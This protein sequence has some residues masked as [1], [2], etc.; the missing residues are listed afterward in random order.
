M[1][2]LGDVNLKEEYTRIIGV[3]QSLGLSN[4]EARVYIA[5][6]AHGFGD[7]ETIASTARIPRTS[8]Y[9]ALQSLCSKEF[10]FST[11]GRPSIYKPEMPDRIKERILREVSN[12][13]DKLSSIHEIVRDKGEPQLVFTITGKVRVMTKIGELLDKSSEKFMISTPTFSEIRESHKKRL[14][15]AIRRGIRVT[16][17]TE[18]GQKVPE[19]ADVHWRRGLIATDVI[20]DGGEALIAS[21][22]LNA[23]GFTDNP[24]LARHLE[25]FLSIMISH[26]PE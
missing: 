5:L 20:V 2:E 18:P 25:S 6:V 16:I 4:Y 8:S 1:E 22:D 7:A 13:F 11:S 21:P 24:Y 14:E 19:G 23:C 3:L 17:I 10:A 15:A 26:G 9:K 12:A